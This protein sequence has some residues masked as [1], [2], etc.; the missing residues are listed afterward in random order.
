[1]RTIVVKRD[2]VR[3]LDSIRIPIE[4]S[5]GPLGMVD[6]GVW[7]LTFQGNEYI[8]DPE[9]KAWMDV[10]TGEIVQMEFEGSPI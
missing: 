3:T 1:M 9:T 6:T 7:R 10:E 5:Q 8:Q 4:G 2:D